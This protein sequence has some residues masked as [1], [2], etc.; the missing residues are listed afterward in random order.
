MNIDYVLDRTSK[1]S[2]PEVKLWSAVIATALRDIWSKP[3]K[4]GK[5]DDDVS[6]AFTY[7][8][9]NDSTWAIEAVGLDADAFRERIQTMMIRGED[10]K[11]RN[12]RLNYR[13]YL[14]T[15]RGLKRVAK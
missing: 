5:L 11:W 13:A 2:P 14:D 3:N 12:A 9:T 7:L 1:S 4:K 15:R 10:F 8:M 6:T